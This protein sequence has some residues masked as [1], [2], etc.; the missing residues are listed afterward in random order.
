MQHP[1]RDVFG[2]NPATNFREYQPEAPNLANGLA[3]R[4]FVQGSERQ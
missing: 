1:Y 3:Y 2:M 4:L